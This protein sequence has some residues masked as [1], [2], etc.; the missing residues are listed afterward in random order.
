MSHLEEGV[1]HAMLDGEI[2]SSELTEVQRHLAG[3]AECRVRLDEAVAL[4]DEAGG[5]VDAIQ[6]TTPVAPRPARPAAAPP[7]WSGRRFRQLAWA[8][9]V[10]AAAGL[11]YVA[12]GPW[13]E[14]VAPP[15]PAPSGITGPA[16]EAPSAAAPETSV[17]TAAVPS[18]P[19]DERRLDAPP[20]QVAAELNRRANEPAIGRQRDSVPVGR[21]RDAV[22][23]DRAAGIALEARAR[24]Q[25]RVQPGRQEGAFA[26]DA[27]AKVAAAPEAAGPTVRGRIVGEAGT[28]LAGAVVRIAE[29]DLQASTDREG[30]YVLGVPAERA[31]KPVTL[32]ARMLG[33]RPA[34]RVLPELGERGRTEDFLLRADGFR[35]VEFADAVGRLGGT[36]RLIDGLTPARHLEAAG[37]EVRIVY[38]LGGRELVLT[39][40]REGATVITTLTGPPGFPADSLAALRAR[41]RE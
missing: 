2:P 28:P 20:Q 37:N 1:L 38:L 30:E 27:V 19:S 18:P 4:R 36:I 14:P 16:Q 22:E 39:Q 11:G 13:T 25:P 26:A 32:T 10:V 7:R 33:F 6:L 23:A 12:R 8:A 21:L 34:T 3:C 24:V 35:P 9:S 31:P 41:I 17:T 40:R 15:E 29:L 5:L